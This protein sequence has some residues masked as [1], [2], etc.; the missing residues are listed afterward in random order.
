MS[1]A[2]GGLARVLIPLALLGSIA[3]CSPRSALAEESAASWRSEQPAP[4]PPPPEVEGSSTPIPLGHVGDIEFIAPD[5]GL[6]ITA[7]N[8][9]TIPAGVWAYDGAGWKELANVCGAT[10]GRIAWAGEDEFWTVS[11]GRAGQSQSSGTSQQAPLADNTLCHFAGGKVVGSYASTAF[12]ASSYQAM[13]AAACLT[14]EDCWFAGAILPVESAVTGSFHLH[15]NGSALLE[16]PYEGESQPVEDMRAFA[17]K[18]F[19]S[20]HVEGAH[21]FEAQP[22]VLHVISPAGVSPTFESIPGVRNQQESFDVPLYETDE[23]VEAL[24][25]LHL[26]AGEHSL[27]AA[28]SAVEPKELANEPEEKKGQVTIAVYSGEEGIWRQVIGPE[29]EPSGETLF[30]KDVVESIAAE[31]GSEGAWVALDSEA[32]AEH[33]SPGAL[34]TVVHVDADGTVS[35]AQTLPSKAE[36][37]RGISPA[38]GASRMICPAAHDCWLSTTQGWLFHL[39]SGDES[40]PVDDE[41]FTSL[42]ASR[43]ADQGLLQLPPD[44]EPEEEALPAE[45]PA[46]NFTKSTA[47]QVEAK[48]TVPLLT[49]LHSRL[50]HGDTLEL[51]FHIAVK[52][53]V[54]LLAKR[55]GTTVASTATKTLAAGD[56]EL[57]LRLNPH[58]WPTKLDLQTHALAP[59]PTVSSRSPSVETITTSLEFP[60]KLESS[61]GPLF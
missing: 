45:A 6:L 60:A 30:G 56:R 18:L 19:E 52:A 59:L 12:E 20:V 38:G 57:S 42:I 13:H 27:W 53:R 36:Q 24:R 15:W 8:G 34:A 7:G 5:R 37:E 43:P 1:R 46:N 54:R 4:P 40:L 23:H 21:R 50:V 48:V 58:R 47:P 25:A 31:P 16:E 61:A 51:R 17:G 55:H 3:M 11:D 9:S 14:A 29:S 35:E 49:H 39:T 26:S 22:P 41:G 32:D 2:L 44:A 28:T 33:P 10:D